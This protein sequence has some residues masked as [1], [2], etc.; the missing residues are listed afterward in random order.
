M[1]H[2][3]SVPSLSKVLKRPDE[4]HMVRHEAAEALGSIA[5]PEVMDLLKDFQED[6]EVV[7]RDSIVVALDMAEYENS[8]ELQYAD[9]LQKEHV[10][11]N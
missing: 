6:Q 4:I 8:G 5:T 1:Q 3:A 11:S 10:M 7:V 2:P 9:G